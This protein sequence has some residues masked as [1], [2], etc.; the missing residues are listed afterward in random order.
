A[1]RRP[2][3]AAAL[4]AGR[5]EGSGWRA[6]RFPDLAAGH[7][8]DDRH[9]AAHRFAHPERLGVPRPRRGRPAEAAHPRS[10]RPFVARRRRARLNCSDAD[11]SGLKLSTPS[12]CHALAWQFSKSVYLR[13]LY[14]LKYI[15]SWYLPIIASRCRIIA[16]T[17]FSACECYTLLSALVAEE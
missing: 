7:R 4:A 14:L 17:S 16:Y 6:H 10:A 15:D 13:S 5:K 2:C 9:D 12:G 11:V 1:P 3:R 8:R